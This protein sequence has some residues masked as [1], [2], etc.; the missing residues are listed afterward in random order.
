MA[1]T[2]TPIDQTQD[3]DFFA[4]GFALLIRTS[5]YHH[6]PTN[7]STTLHTSMYQNLFGITS[8]LLVDKEKHFFLPI[9]ASTDD[10][11][12]KFLRQAHIE[13]GVNF[14]LRIHNSETQTI[15]KLQRGP[16]GIYSPRLRQLV[17]YYIL[18]CAQCLRQRQTIIPTPLGTRHTA[19]NIGPTLSQCSIDPFGFYKCKLFPDSRQSKKI[20]LLAIKCLFSGFI[21]IVMLDSLKSS[22]ISK[23]LQSVQARY[24]V[25]ITKLY[26]DN[27][28]NLAS[29]SLSKFDND[30]FYTSLQ[31]IMATNQ[32][33][34]KNIAPAIEGSTAYYSN[35]PYSQFRNY[36]ESSIKLIK[37]YFKHLTNDTVTLP[38]L[39]NQDWLLLCDLVAGYLNRLPYSN[40]TLICPLALI[41]PGSIV[42]DYEICA[43]EKEYEKLTKYLDIFKTTRLDF[44]MAEATKWAQT[45][46]KGMHN[47]RPLDKGDIIFLTTNP[48]IG[49]KNLHFCI[50]EDTIGSNFKVRD[51]SNHTFEVARKRCH[52]YI[53]KGHSFSN[54]AI[55]YHAQ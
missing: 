12:Q 40:K 48:K 41:F 23:A 22:D 11:L 32:I 30:M 36:S 53:P 46:Y 8:R 27:A 3:I 47:C 50:I 26:A 49:N 9:L 24:G 1:V 17:A 37:K 29:N 25:K 4:E 6:R 2:Y 14:T 34:I 52:P 55:G 10:V 13:S 21:S 16:F 20:Y 38:T 45:K 31:E 43:T 54:K 15:N 35:L 18:G 39:N 44:L 33:V 7:N 42:H 5:Q 28:S 19:F 51:F